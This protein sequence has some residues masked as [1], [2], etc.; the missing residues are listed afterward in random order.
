[1][2]RLAALAVLLCLAALAAEDVVAAPQPG[3]TTAA[4]TNDLVSSTDA[5]TIPQMMSHQDRLT[6]AVGVQPAGGSPATSAAARPRRWLCGL[7]ELGVRDVKLARPARPTLS[8]S[9]SYRVKTH[10]RIH[11]TTSGVDATTLRYAELTAVHAETSWARAVR[12]GWNTPPPD[13]NVGGDN[14][15]DIYIRALSGYAG[16]TPPDSAYTALYPDG[17]SSWIEIIPNEDTLGNLQ[18]LVG[19]EFHHAC[20]E[21]YSVYERPLWWFYENTS[22]WME[23]LLFPGLGGLYSETFWNPSPLTATNLAINARAGNYE[24][25]GGMWPKFLAE[26]YDLAAPRRIWDLGGRHAGDHI[27]QDTDSILRTYYSTY[28]QTA[29]GHYA[30]WRYFTGS[31]D[32]NLHYLSAERCTA[33]VVHARHTTYPASGN[34]GTRSPRGPGG[35]TLVEFVTSGSQDITINFDGQ[36]GYDWRAYVLA[37]RGGVTYEQYILLGAGGGGSITIPAWMVTTA[38]LV[39]VASEWSDAADSTPALTFSYSASVNDNPTGLA[40]EGARQPALELFA[41][42]PVRGPATL[43]YVLPQGVKGTLRVTDAAG[44]LAQEFALEGTGRAAVVTMG[45]EAV[46]A[47]VYLCQLA[48]GGDVLQSKLVMQQ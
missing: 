1:M 32:D 13:Q 15:Y 12:L 19:H 33:A 22:T 9:V 38:V 11:Y 17:S 4:A 7:P 24:Y 29:V 41:P 35:T 18:T 44:R 48:A 45:R 28:L 46:P 20:Q 14:L 40:G 31:R 27:Q 3:A 16:V 43:R 36:D 8:G 39:P 34:Q 26:Y 25:P 10:F 47:G 30:I 37:R 42:S 5:V 21:S 23:D 2:T 6:D